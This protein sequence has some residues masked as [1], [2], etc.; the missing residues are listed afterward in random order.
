MQ[1]ENTLWREGFVDLLSANLDGAGPLRTVPP[2][3]VMRN[4]EGSA[5]VES[6]VAFGK[7]TGARFVVL[8]H[9][10]AA[11]HDSA[12]V[13]AWLRGRRDAPSCRADRAA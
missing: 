3:V 1:G 13:T 6:A 12:R 11:G 4:W 2:S 9:V 10:L 5:D 7:R 8:G